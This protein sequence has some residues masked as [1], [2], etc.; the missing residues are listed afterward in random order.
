MQLVLDDER[1]WCTD[2][3]AREQLSYLF[4]P[5]HLCELVDGAEDQFGPNPVDVLV[6]DIRGQA[7]AEVAGLVPAGDP[8]T[9]D[10]RL[11]HRVVRLVQI[12]TAPRALGQLNRV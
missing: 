4:A 5:G 6:D 7:I 10:G 12:L 3:I 1:R 11:H 8:E 9:L 2:S